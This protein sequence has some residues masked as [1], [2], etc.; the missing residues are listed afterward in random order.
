MSDVAPSPD[1]RLEAIESKL[2]FQEHTIAQLDDV[3]TALRK[4]VDQ[5]RDVQRVLLERLR[6]M[7][8]ADAPSNTAEERPPH[9]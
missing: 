5:L 9:Y 4:E 1:T 7:G 6:E 3:V 2:A 8:D